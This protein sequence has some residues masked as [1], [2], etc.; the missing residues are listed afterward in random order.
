M[1]SSTFAACAAFALFGVTGASAQDSM[2]F[3]D[4]RF[5][6]VPKLEEA[7]D[8]LKVHYRHGFVDIEKR[9]VLDYVTSAGGSGFQPTTDEERANVD[10]G[11]VP[12]EGGWVTPAKRDR[13]LKKVR[14]EKAAALEEYKKHQKWR[15]RHMVRT[16]HFDFEFTVPLEV[17]EDYMEMFEVFYEHYAKEWKAKQK[18]GERLKVCF[19]NDKDDFHRIGNV[20][21]GVLGYY[22]FVEPRELN[23]FYE[24]RDKLLTLDVLFH[25]LNHYMFD[26]VCVG[27]VH[28]PAWISEG[29]SEYYGSARW[30]PTTKKMTYG[31]IQ[32]G[33]LVALR[34][35]MDG[36]EMQDL[37]SLMREFDVSAIQYAWGWTLGH[38][39]MEDPK[40]SKKFK[41]YI[42]KLARDKSIKRE[43]N[44]RNTNFQWVPPDVAIPL[45]QKTLGISDLDA[46]EEEWYQYIRGLDVQTAR[47]Y[48]DAAMFCLRWD[49]PLRAGMY[50]KKAIDEFY[51]D[52]P[53]TYEAYGDFLLNE[54]KPGEA[55]VVI[56][57]GLKLDPMNP[58]MH[59]MLGKAYRELGGEGN[60]D[61]G[62]HLQLM[63]IEMDANDL[64]LYSGLD[65]DVLE[66]LEE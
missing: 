7:G 60:R 42:D 10:K 39:L 17:G 59:K 37:Q 2:F 65:S 31:G 49:R 12:F 15:D 52:N 55:I 20:Q 64:G 33:R 16:K 19:Y 58:Y 44:P 13:E 14:E 5:Y 32:E 57:K 25:E 45:F 3:R 4:G 28:L 8:Q 48:H 56:E 24:R 40:Y 38:M 62:K 30:D 53:G 54:K 41:T 51:S 47:G 26:L 27:D 34:D 61:K 63:A 6:E 50:L 18:S 36:G 1:R 11:L 9:L 43:P 35:E 66:A 29:M 23:F 22:R 46:F 21:R